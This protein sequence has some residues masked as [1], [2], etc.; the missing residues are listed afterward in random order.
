MRKSIIFSL[1]SI[2]LCFTIFKTI[3]VKPSYASIPYNE[4]V[5]SPG[6]IAL[7]SPNAPL[8]IIMYY[9]LA[10]P[11][12]AEFKLEILPKIRAQFINTNKLYFVMRAFPLDEND[13]KAT[14]LAWCFGQSRANEIMGLLVRNQSQWDT[15]NNVES[16]LIRLATSL[17]GITAQQCRACFANQSLEKKI[18]QLRFDAD[19]Q[20]EILYTPT[21]IIDGKVIEADVDEKFIASRLRSMG[22]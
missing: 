18:L 8:K 9:A 5:I 11:H 10:C 20:F 7:G 12:C 4:V 13:L 14:Q 1:V 3:N 2:S 21:F 15:T 19:K 16:A 6:E 17:P 22:Y